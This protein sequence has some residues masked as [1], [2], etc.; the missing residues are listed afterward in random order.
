MDAVC[1]CELKRIVGRL[2]RAAPLPNPVLR[3]DYRLRSIAAGDRARCS[4]K[5]EGPENFEWGGGLVAL[6]EVGAAVGRGV[7][8][9]DGVL[10]GGG[11][12]VC[13]DAVGGHQ[14]D[15]GAAVAT[16]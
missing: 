3:T 11:G 16:G 14:V 8:F 10:F 5:G 4:L 9:G 15:D 2:G 6:L 13:G 1:L 12:F 7:V